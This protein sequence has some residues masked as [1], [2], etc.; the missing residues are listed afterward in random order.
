MLKHF[1]R[2]WVHLVFPTGQLI[3]SA[4]LY[5]NKFYDQLVIPPGVS[6][7][8]FLIE[9]R[10]ARPNSPLRLHLGCGEVFLRNYVNIDFPPSSHTVQHK[11]VADVFADLKDLSFPAFSVDEVRLH[12]VFEH[13]DRPTSL[14]LLCTWQQWL[15]IGGVLIIETPDFEAAV[16]RMLHS[17]NQQERS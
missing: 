1:W 12:H 2:Y 3:R 5:V 11:A 15:K 17:P 9:K 4:G 10:I 8:D 6:A 13:F 16:K 14:A 7:F